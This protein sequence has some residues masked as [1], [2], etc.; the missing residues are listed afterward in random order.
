MEAEEDRKSATRVFGNITL[1]DIRYHLRLLKMIL[2]Y[3]I[4]EL[5]NDT[6][7]IDDVTLFF[8]LLIVSHPNVT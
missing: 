6:S 1:M 3:L 7:Q 2:Q 4:T 5:S 8:L